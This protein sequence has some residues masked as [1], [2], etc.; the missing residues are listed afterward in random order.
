[1]DY[2]HYD[3][4]GLVIINNNNYRL[5]NLSKNTKTRTIKNNDGFSIKIKRDELRISPKTYWNINTHYDQQ[6]EGYDASCWLCGWNGMDYDSCKCKKSFSIEEHQGN[7]IKAR[8][9]FFKS[10]MRN[11]FKEIKLK[12]LNSLEIN[13]IQ[14]V[15]YGVGKYGERI[16]L[17]DFPYWNNQKS[18]IE[19]MRK[20][21][22]KFKLIS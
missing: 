6:F 20:R 21:L 8:T 19:K 7:L 15:M 17:I 1:M 13:F 5:S 9:R 2:I 22:Q 3:D 14:K 12:T 16:L 18:D 4:Y 11:C 10:V